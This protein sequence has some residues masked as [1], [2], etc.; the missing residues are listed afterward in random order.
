VNFV[1]FGVPVHFCQQ[2]LAAMMAAL[3]FAGVIVARVRT[4]WRSRWERT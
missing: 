4:W 2:E 1:I 3:P